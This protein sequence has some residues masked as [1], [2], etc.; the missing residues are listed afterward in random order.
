KIELCLFDASGREE[1]ARIELPA[2]TG[3]IWHGHV[4][5]L[6]PGQIYGYRVYGPHDPAQGHL[7]DPGRI[8]F[9]PY[10]KDVT[11][12]LMARVAAPAVAQT[13]AKPSTPWPDTIIM[14]THLR[15]MTMEFPD[16]PDDIRGTCAGLCDDRV[17][18]HL[19][20][21][22][23]TALE[24]LPVMAFTSEPHLRKS[25]L[26]N[27]WGYNTLGFFA[28]HPR[29]GSPADFKAMT[30]KLHEAGIEIILDVVYNHTA[31]GSAD[32]PA[33]SF[34]GIDNAS[35]Y[36]LDPQDKRSCIDYTG[37]GNTLDTTQPHVR[38][39]IVDS[40]RYWME[41][42][43]VDGFRFDLAAALGRDKDGIFRRDHPLFAEIANDPVLSHAKLI[44]EP[45]DI[46]PSGYQPG[47]FPEGW[48]EW[49]DRFRDNNRAWWRGDDRLIGGMAEGLAGS[50]PIFGRKS[51]SPHVG[52]NFGTAHDGFTLLDAASYN[53]KHNE[54][55]REGNR[56]G[57]N[58][59]L[60][61]NH[62]AEGPTDDPAI[63]RSRAQATRSIMASLLLSQGTPMLLAGDE[64]GNSQKGNNNAYCQDN[65]VG[66]VNWDGM[67]DENRDLRAMIHALTAL[68]RENPVLRSREFLHGFNSC[69]LGIPDISWIN[70]NGNDMIWDDP[71]ARC[72]GL[73][74][75]NGAI[76]DNGGNQDR[77]LMVFNANSCNTPFTLPEL[78]GG[79][80]WRRIM[81]TQNPAGSAPIPCAEGSA[82]N[83]GPNTVSIF[84]QTPCR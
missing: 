9:D 59:N 84:I 75:N 21:L 39:M 40:L 31:E 13:D 34:R 2:R 66:W 49:N 63:L 46:G 45:W 1:T 12:S 42:M 4:R 25:G 56:D 76:P 83:I 32:A 14:E 72:L 24:I 60:S 58:H 26:T 51:L 17:I 22:G 74:L 53:D 7:F 19:K 55:N 16:L 23:V 44:A 52:I 71:G 70:P 35:Y 10:A 30:R 81:D 20:Y 33:S 29:Y 73:M 48:H 47:N 62:G 65:P 15:G 82:Q 41:E 50:H 11:D 37:C 8:L 3:D 36:R 77:L 79:L 43:G 80:G 18:D 6:A 67:G 54:M 5:G 61:F 78:K 68:R 57:C 69:A 64:V 27:Y 28:L 38:R